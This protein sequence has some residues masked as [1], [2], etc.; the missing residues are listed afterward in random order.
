MQVPELFNAL[1]YLQAWNTANVDSATVGRRVGRLRLLQ[2]GHNTSG[3]IHRTLK[4][5]T[6]GQRSHGLPPKKPPD[7]GQTTSSPNVLLA[8]LALTS[9]ARLHHHRHN[10]T[11]AHQFY[12]C[13]A[14]NSKE[15]GGYVVP[16]E[17]YHTE[18]G[19]G[20]AGVRE[21]AAFEGYTGGADAAEG[22]DAESQVVLP[23]GFT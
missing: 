23:Q 10:G 7:A 2:D 15:G 22:Q 6:G 5:P 12:G 9:A 1:Q 8:H 13:P 19:C 18:D 3:T 14:G 17:E 21:L 4:S 11:R 20:D 16:A